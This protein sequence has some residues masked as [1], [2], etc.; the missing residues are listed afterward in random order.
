MR[1]IVETA[2]L[3][4]LAL[5]L[6]AAP[7]NAQSSSSNRYAYCQQQAYQQSGWNGSVQSGSQH[8]PLGGA[9]AGAIGGS[10]VG[11][12]GGGDAGRGAAIGAAFGAV[13]G[14]ARKNQAAQ[15]QQSSE[16]TYYN[17]LNACMAQ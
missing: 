16:Q 11:G 5:S 3:A 12:M 4:A 2:A 7:S 15:K 17:V 13:F 6:A 10:L 14:S 9:A 1:R 8:A